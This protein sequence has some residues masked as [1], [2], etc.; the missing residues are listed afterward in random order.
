[1]GPSK[2]RKRFFLDGS[3]FRK[4][5]V[6][7]LCTVD[8]WRNVSGSPWWV[9]TTYFWLCKFEWSQPSTLNFLQEI[10]NLVI[11]DSGRKLVV[12]KRTCHVVWQNGQLIGIL[13]GT[14][15]LIIISKINSSEHHLDDNNCTQHVWQGRQHYRW[16]RWSPGMV[17]DEA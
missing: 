12:W 8:Q 3:N 2:Q 6:Q 17:S 13:R 11:L 16:N 10:A 9:I 5:C 14:W 7:Y 4:F 15:L 1:M